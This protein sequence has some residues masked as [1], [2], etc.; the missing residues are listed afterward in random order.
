MDVSASPSVTAII[1]NAPLCRKLLL[2][3]AVEF[4]ITI[5]SPFYRLDY[6]NYPSLAFLG[7]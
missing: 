1:P 2:L 4:D 7:N 3:L 5:G 6:E